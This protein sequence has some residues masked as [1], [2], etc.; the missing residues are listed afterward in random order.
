[1]GTSSSVL[2]SSVLASGLLSKALLKSEPGAYWDMGEAGGAGRAEERSLHGPNSGRRLLASLWK[3][4][5]AG[6]QGDVTSPLLRPPLA[7]GLRDPG[8]ESAQ[9]GGS[10]WGKQ[11]RRKRVGQ[12]E[13]QRKGAPW[14]HTQIPSSQ[15]DSNWRVQKGGSGKG[16]QRPLT[17]QT[18]SPAGWSWPAHLFK[19]LIWIHSV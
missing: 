14:P 4:S 5:S 17:M 10:E 16:K 15:T 3:A 18:G 8:Q 11:W 13:K 6:L 2:S 9:E 12:P 19:Q 1:M 7:P